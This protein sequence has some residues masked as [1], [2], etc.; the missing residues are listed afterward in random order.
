MVSRSL[1]AAAIAFGLVA[2]AAEAAWAQSRR[3][4]PFEAARQRM[5]EEAVVGAGVKDPRVIGAMRETPRHEFLPLSERKRAYLDMGLPIG[6][7]QTISAPF[8]VA[9]MT[10]QLDPQ[11]TDKVLEIG[12]GSGYQ[13]AVLSGLVGE[14]YT[15]E[16]VGSLARKAGRTLKRLGYRNVHVKA[17][18]GFQGWAEHAPFD[19]IIVTCSPEKVP[20]PLVQQLREG[21]RIVI[22]VGPRFQQTLYLFRKVAGRLEAEALEPVL[23]VPMTG[24]AEELRQRQPD[25]ANPAIFNG[26]F[27]QVLEN[28]EQ[29]LGWHYQRQLKLE[30]Q[31]AP[32][33]EK[34]VTFSNDEAG[35]PAV[36]LQGLAID[37]REVDAIEISLKVRG[38]EL[39][40]DLRRKQVPGVYVTFY[41]E[42]R[43]MLD[44][45][46]VGGW[47]GDFDW[48]E[49][50][51]RVPV[52]K[53]T[54]EAIVQIGLLGA[55]GKLSMDAIELKRVDRR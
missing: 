4:D 45:R 49:V 38:E 3:T 41:D 8:I 23:F 33:G 20:Q 15:I 5:V 31:E 21:G 32:S 12:T 54:R 29:P 46:G 6:E 51:V 16:I 48:R 55:V 47:F 40:P 7:Q 2:V 52:P 53:T 25:P 42:D 10:E 1:T 11:P 43:K 26:D 39:W 19:K 24:D 30:T 22:P 37:G 17:G 36:A 14:V 13:A 44:R 9:Y 34:Y 28:T 18:D 35:L 50:S 27:E